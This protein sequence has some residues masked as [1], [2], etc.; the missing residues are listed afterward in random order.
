MLRRHLLSGSL[1]ALAAFRPSAAFSRAPGIL[2]AEDYRHYVEA[3]NRDDHDDI[4]GYIHNAQAWDWMKEQI[5]FFACP[6]QDIESTYYYRWWAYRKHI[7]KTPAGFIITEFLRPVSHATQYNAIS[8]ALGHHIAEGRWLAERRYL[9]D[10]VAFWLHGGPG[11]A[12]QPAFHKYSGW[13]SAALYD[14]WLVDGDTSYLVAQLDSLEADYAAWEHERLTP[15]GL[16]WQYD[17]ADG[18]EESV[19]GGRHIQNIRPSINSYMYGNAK[20]IGA[21][22]A[23]AGKPAVE[24]EYAAKAS[25]LRQLVQQKLWDREAQFFETV[26]ASGGFANVR[27]EIGFTPWYFDL[28]ERGKGDEVAWKQL[29]DPRG[30]Y[31]PY[32]PTTAERRS[33]GFRIAN[34]GDDCQWNGPS[35]AFATTITLRSAANVLN[36]YSSSSL[37][38]QDYFKTLLIYARSQRLRLP[39][40][41]VIPFIDE[42]QNPLTGE[43]QARR[44]KIREGTFYGRGDHYNHSAYADLI[45]TG[46]AGLRPQPGADLV[47]N[48]LLPAGM[49]DWFCLDRVRY[50]GRLLTVLWDRTGTRFGKGKGLRLFVDGSEAAH[51]AALGRLSGRLS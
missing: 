46:L 49:W 34:E 39:D 20:A 30:F 41:R 3:F 12:F 19:S 13:L 5:P 31:A 10:Y 14:R 18:M 21:I 11:G 44:M 29:M 50:H 40:G 45:I 47:V 48:P 28:P 35:W 9:D 27:E 8:C 7:E 43:W 2:N 51:S 22:A 36:D 23:L 42:D 26:L 1:G 25:R 6:D 33:P 38:V 15:S 4:A 24:A 17:V 37:T 16:F 32:G